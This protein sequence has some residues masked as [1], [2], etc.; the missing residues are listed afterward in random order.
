MGWLDGRVAVITG[1]GR[2]LGRAH[3]LFLASEGA[4]V[5]VNDLGASADGAVGGAEESTGAG[6]AEQ[7]AA[8]IRAGGG[9][10]VANT[11]DVASWDGGRRLVETAVE[12]FGDVHVL[13]N[14]AG[15][16]RDR[17]LVTMTEDDWDAIMNVHVKGHFVPTRWAA[18]HWRERHK[19][20]DRVP[21]AVIHTSSTS[22]L[23][24]NPGQSNYGTAKSAIATFSQICAKELHRYGVVSNCIAPA[25]RTRLTESAPGLEELVQPPS[26]SATFDQWD[27]FNVSPL[28][29]YLAT[30]DCP[31][32]GSTFYIHGA[33][34]R[35]IRGW[36]MGEGVE[37][38]DRWDVAGLAKEMVRLL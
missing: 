16:L 2:G 12:S 37:R 1:A 38:P 14:N 18:A 10:A 6:A 31:F 32:N 28:V 34:I 3:A 22:G 33:T 15:I 23:L 30:P 36:E 27:P 25:A 4:S 26:D 29:A 11:D 35:L 13:V 7:V 17:A 8:E 20:G 24:A 21:R 19:A 9:R 5:V